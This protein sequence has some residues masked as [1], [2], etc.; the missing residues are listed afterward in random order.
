M[1]DASENAG[2]LFRAGKL[3]QAIAAANAEVRRRPGDLGCRIL[4]AELLVFSRNLD[5]ADLILDATSRADPASAVVIAEFR[6]LLRGETARRQVG[7]E[8]RVPE[9]LGA[10]PPALRAALAARAA[11]RAGDTAEAMRQAAAIETARPR[12]PGELTNGTGK[13]AFDDFRDIDDLCAGFFE[14]L[15][16]T[17]KY[18][19]I[20]TE[21]VLSIAFHPPR[22]PRDLAWRR[23]T[24]SVSSGPDGEVYLPAIYDSLRSDL[25]DDHRLGLASDW[26]GEDEGAPMQGIGRRVF[27]AG[28]DACSVMD[29]VE[30]RF[31]P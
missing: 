16:T 5:R 24:M 27:L 31:G 1:S 10:P 8:G 9:F 15:T 19:W 6:Q 23:A 12:T 18:Y 22:R 4:L 21:R 30:L 13:I 29:I 7:R 26:R 11:S 25:S 2:A 28:D 17:G 20:P 14:V 3:D